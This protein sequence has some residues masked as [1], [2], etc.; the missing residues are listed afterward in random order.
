MSRDPDRP[1]TDSSPTSPGG[2]A[3]RILFAALALAALAGAIW[4]WN[5]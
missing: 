5:R 2:L 3:L 4:Y 1:S